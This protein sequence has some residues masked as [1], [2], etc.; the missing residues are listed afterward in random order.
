MICVI[1]NI[2][3]FLLTLRIGVKF[4]SVIIC[5]YKCRDLY[6]TLC[7]YDGASKYLIL[8]TSEEI[9]G[10]GKASG[11]SAAAPECRREDSRISF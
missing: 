6:L 8:H 5:F 9:S 2:V 1:T 11:A 10:V 4:I 7:T 3:H